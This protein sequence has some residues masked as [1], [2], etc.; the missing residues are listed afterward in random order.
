MSKCPPEDTLNVDL[1]PEDKSGLKIRPC[2][3][4]TETRAAR[5]AC[6]KDQAII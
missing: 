1:Y 6:L 3:A 5:E 4:C 2:M